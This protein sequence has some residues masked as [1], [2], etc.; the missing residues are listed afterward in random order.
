[1]KLR[2]DDAFA[3]VKTSI[4]VHTLG[5]STIMSFIRECGYKVYMASEEVQNAVTDIKKINNL[6]FVKRW[7]EDNGITQIAFSYRLDPNDGMDYFCNFYYLLKDSKMFESDGGMIRGLSFAGLPDTCDLIRRKLGDDILLFP[8]DETPIESLKKYGVTEDQFPKTL[9]QNNSYDNMRWDFAKKLIAGEK[10]KHVSFQN[11]YGYKE[12]G[13][14]N[15]TYESRLDYSR[16][17]H[18]LPII[19]AHVGPYNSNRLEALKEFTSWVKDLS[20]SRLLDVLSIG[21]SQLTQSNFGENWDGKHNGGGVPINSE[22]EYK[23][24]ADAA[25]PMLVRTYAGTKN[26]PYMAMIH[27]RSLNISWHALSLWWFCEIDGRGKNTVLENLKE[28][29]ETIKYIASTGKPFEPN[30]PHHFAFRGA[31]DITYI[32]SGYLAAKTAKKYGITHLILQNM[33][34]TPKYTWGVQDLAKGRAMLKLVR[35]L[36]DSNFKVS[37]QT[38]AGLDYFAPDIEKAK[39]QL[40]SVTA[41]MDD[42]EP[43]NANSPEI[44][45]VVSYSEAVRLATPPII[46]ESIQI[47][48][49]ALNEYR[50]LRK[51]GKIENMTYNK[52]VDDR[53]NN[54]YNESREAISFLEN[55][56][57]NLYTPEG[58][59]SV[60]KNGYFPV[61]YMPDYDH[62]YPNATKWMTA[63]KNGG[64]WVVDDKG[65]VMSTIYRYK[66][67]FDK[68]GI[69]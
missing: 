49:S 60:F 41:L 68:G 54:L 34:N 16:L 3:F 69:S 40:A 12:C 2:N 27:E 21:S 55:H 31:D 61:P 51:S 24:I 1:M 13:T 47:T 45:H 26:V 22:I 44:I 62:K 67:I 43:D 18:S 14:A 17:H 10:Y 15:D 33:L 48:L 42:I 11:H 50:Y 19:R 63:I 56:I 37:L 39:I 59:F 57:P 65:N 35:G 53:F 6:S 66:T 64:V 28:H 7:I 36:E 38:R 52:E 46:K 29:L 32:V 4:D 30:V 9:V 25:K 20:Q 58:L 5:I 8:G 23:Q